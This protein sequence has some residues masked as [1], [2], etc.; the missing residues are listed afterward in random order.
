VPL[1][2]F[3]SDAKK[4]PLDKVTKQFISCPKIFSLHEI[5]FSWQKFFSCSKKKVLDA[6]NKILRQKNTSFVI[7]S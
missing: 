6:R 5:F 3:F 7:L 1:T 2:E 4:I